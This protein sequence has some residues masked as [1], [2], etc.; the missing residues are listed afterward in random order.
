MILKMWWYFHLLP[1]FAILQNDIKTGYFFLT[2]L[3]PENVLQAFL[4]KFK[5]LNELE[6]Y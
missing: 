2:S 3:N 5:L 4:E 6:I 1:T